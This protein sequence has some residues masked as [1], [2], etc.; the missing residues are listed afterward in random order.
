LSPFIQVNGV[1]G[2]IGLF[3]NPECIDCALLS[4]DVAVDINYSRFY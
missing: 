2:Y 4:C 3:F 1:V